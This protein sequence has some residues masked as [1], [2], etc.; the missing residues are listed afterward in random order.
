MQSVRR[1]ERNSLWTRLYHISFKLMYFISNWFIVSLTFLN[2][3]FTVEEISKYKQFSITFLN[4]YVYTSAFTIFLYVCDVIKLSINLLFNFDTLI[5]VS[6][7]NK[8]KYI[9]IYV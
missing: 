8:K 6:S 9:H 1:E 5:K 3:F 7:E 4:N 2:Y